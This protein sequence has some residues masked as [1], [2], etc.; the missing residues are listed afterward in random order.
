MYTKLNIT[1]ANMTKKYLSFALSLCAWTNGRLRIHSVDYDRTRYLA[2][3]SKTN[4]KK[5]MDYEQNRMNQTIK[6]EFCKFRI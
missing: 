6:N 4:M 3:L 5:M 1:P 2:N